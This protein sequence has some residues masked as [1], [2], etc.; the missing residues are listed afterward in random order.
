MIQTPTKNYSVSTAGSSSSVSIPYIQITNP[1]TDTT[2]FPVGKRWINQGS[3]TVFCL[4]SEINNPIIKTITS[5]WTILGSGNG[6][7]KN[8]HPNEGTSPVLPDGGDIS[9]TAGSPNLRIVGS[10]SQVSVR[11]IGEPEINKIQLNG[12]SGKI[13]FTDVSSSTSSVG[14]SGPFVDGQVTVVTSAC[15]SDSYIVISP[16]A[17]P[18]SIMNGQFSIGIGPALPYPAETVFNYWIINKSS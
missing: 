15:K 1:L 11:L 5:I 18:F 7:L 6:F 9:I 17:V 16:I 8:F 13:Y 14:T 2:N 3:D 12:L 10:A 4:T